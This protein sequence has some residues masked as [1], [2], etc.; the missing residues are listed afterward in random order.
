M[1]ESSFL[2]IIL[3]LWSVPVLMYAIL[4]L[5]E[6]NQLVLGRVHPGRND[7]SDNA[8]IEMPFEYL[9]PMVAAAAVA[10]IFSLLVAVSWPVCLML[11]GA[12]AALVGG[13]AFT[14]L[15]M[16]SLGL[17]QKARTPDRIV[18]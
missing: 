6:L 11:M 10:L 9:L 8:G 1:T 14:F 16:Y 15:Q 3:L 4:F 2:M 18:P 5:P 12:G 13:V 7:K 17:R